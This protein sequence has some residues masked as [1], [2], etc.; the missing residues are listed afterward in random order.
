MEERL[1]VAWLIANSPRNRMTK[2]ALITYKKNLRWSMNTTALL[3]T[4]KI[5]SCKML[6]EI[7]YHKTANDPI[8]SWTLVS[9]W[10]QMKSTRL[11]SLPSVPYVNKALIMRTN[12]ISMVQ[13][14]MSQDLRSF[15]KINIRTI[16]A[17]TCFLIKVALKWSLKNL[18]RYHNK[19][20]FW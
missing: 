6:L 7:F 11:S 16:M 20:N 9:I 8:W 4:Q 3:W 2:E 10:S 5:H 17:I 1:S 15:N 13:F 18:T 14:G 19:I 12:R